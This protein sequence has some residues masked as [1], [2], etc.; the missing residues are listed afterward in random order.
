MI[1]LKNQRISIMGEDTVIKQ[2]CVWFKTPFG[3]FETLSAAIEKVEE[4]GINP[5]MSIIP[6][7]VAVGLG[8][9]EP[10]AR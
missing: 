10:F 4:V 6:I 8:I 7:P 5:E 1:D 9:Y 3:M 2:W